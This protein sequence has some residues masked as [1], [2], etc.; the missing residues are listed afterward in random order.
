MLIATE[1]GK[2][3]YEKMGFKTVDSVHKYICDNYTISKRIT[4]REVTVE[5]LDEKDLNEILILDKT[6][7]GDKR[8]DFLTQNKSI[9]AMFGS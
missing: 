6:A 5:N 4:N 7:F 1:D 8:S 2:P 3:L 9:R